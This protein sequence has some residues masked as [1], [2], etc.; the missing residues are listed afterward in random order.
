[1][2]LSNSALAPFLRK[3][4]RRS[5]L[6]DDE[7]AAILAL[8]IRLEQVAAQRDFVRLGENVSHSCLIVA[9]LAGRFGQ[10][11]EGNRQITALHIPGDMADLHSAVTPE[12]T[13][14]LQAL[15]PTTIGKIP[16]SAIRRTAAAYPAVAEALWRECVIDG[17]VLSEWVV[18]IGRRNASMR[19]AHLLCETAFRYRMG[20]VVEHFPFAFPATQQHLADMLGLTPVHVNRTLRVLDTSGL[21]RSK[22]G[23]VEILS[24][25]R[26]CE[27]AEFD[28]VYLQLD[29]RPRAP[30]QIGEV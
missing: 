20:D 7:Q 25:Q 16:H 30:M 14:A 9:G 17:A 12:A 13:S 3:V 1:M 15:T 26:I 24:W 11:R 21:V 2:T 8:P 28:P 6:S 4:L 27:F 18:N 23:V 22:R 29:G 5:I 10:G 19:L